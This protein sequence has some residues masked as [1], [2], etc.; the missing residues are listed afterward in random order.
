MKPRQI[1]HLIDSLCFSDH[2]MA[3]VSGSRQCGKTTLARMMLELRGCGC[4]HNWD[5][6]EFRRLWTKN[7]KSSIPKM[8]K[9]VCPLVIYD[10]IH[11]AK[12]WKRTIKGFYDTREKFADILVTGSA[13]LNVYRRG[14]D[15]LF[16]RYYHFRL[17]PFRF[18]K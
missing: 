16:G 10:E 14:S 1:E 9:T 2:K 8:K 5:D 12:L 13:R 15:S 17:H 11:K 6:I 18:A 3:F 7:L 4:Y